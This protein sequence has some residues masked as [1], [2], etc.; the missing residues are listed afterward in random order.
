MPDFKEDK[1]S[2][3]SARLLHALSIRFFASAARA[4]GRYFLLIGFVLFFLPRYIPAND[5][6]MWLVFLLALYGLW[7]LIDLLD[8]KCRDYFNLE[9]K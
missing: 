2:R 7:K 8:E 5:S 9:E 6:F 3:G 4:F 1:P